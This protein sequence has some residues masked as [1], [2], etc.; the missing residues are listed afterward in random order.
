MIQSCSYVKG[1]VAFSVSMTRPA[2]STIAFV[3]S[4]REAAEKYG[5]T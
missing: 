4:R 3:L 1:G 2:S 5:Y